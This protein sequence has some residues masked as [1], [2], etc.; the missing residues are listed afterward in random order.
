MPPRCHDYL[1]GNCTNNNIDMDEIKCSG[2]FKLK[3]R[4]LDGKV[5]IVSITIFINFA[6]ITVFGFAIFSYIQGCSLVPYIC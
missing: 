5:S 3:A 2:G 4:G 1:I 6:F